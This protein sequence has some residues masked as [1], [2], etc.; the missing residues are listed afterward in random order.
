MQSYRF[1]LELPSDT[2]QAAAYNA[3]RRH[4]EKTLNLLQYADY[5]WHGSAIIPTK[6]SWSRFNY[7]YKAWGL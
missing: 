4:I 6:P 1:Q 2:R 3:G 5:M 7:S